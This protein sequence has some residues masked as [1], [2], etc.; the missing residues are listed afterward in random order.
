M[1]PAS[2]ANSDVLAFYR[3]LPFNF[4]GATAEAVAR[5]RKL[6]PIDHYPPL[7]SIIRPGMRVLDVGCGCGW[8]V[9]GLAHHHQVRATGLDFNSVAL[10]QGREIAQALGEDIEFIEGDLFV[11]QPDEPYD[12]V[13]SLGVLHHT[14][15]C[16]AGLRHLGKNL[17]RPGGHLFVGLYH[18]HGRRPLLAHFARLKAAG[19]DEEELY[20]A[21]RELDARHMDEVHARSWFRDQVLHPHETQHTLEEVVPVLQETGLVL[22]ATSINRFRPFESLEELY[23]REAELA[24]VAQRYLDERHYFPGFFVFHAMKQSS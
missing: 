11:Y 3:Q 17:V 13:T 9:N 7:K 1:M 23:R 10:D 15:D 14:N 20:R 4:Y 16:L 8:F 18:A 24:V 12:L 6:D 2:Y 21:Y 22:E 19:A 5:I